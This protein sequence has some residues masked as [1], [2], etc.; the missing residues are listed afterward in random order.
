MEEWSEPEVHY[1][2]QSVFDYL[3]KDGFRNLDATL[4]FNVE[5]AANHLILRTCLT[6]L[7]FSDIQNFAHTY[8][9]LL[10]FHYV[11]LKR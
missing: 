11:D 3:V 8:S 2:H 10:F 4:L 6:C 9:D 1:V 5:G 7:H